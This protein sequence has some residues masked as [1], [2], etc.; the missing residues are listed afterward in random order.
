[1]GTSVQAGEPVSITRTDAV[2][3]GEIRYCRPND[4]GSFDVGVAILGFRQRQ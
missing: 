1:L 3:S 2:I 4:A